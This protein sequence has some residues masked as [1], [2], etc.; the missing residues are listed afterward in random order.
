MNV[1]AHIAALDREGRLMAESAAANGL[2]AVVAACPGWRVRDLLAHTGQVHRWAAAHVA[3]GNGGPPVRGQAAK[4]VFPHPGDDTLLDWFRD[5]H[6]H[7]VRTLSDAAPDTECLTFLPAPSPLAFWARRQ[8][9][10]TAV[11]RVDAQSAHPE[12]APAPEEG[13]ADPGD[14]ALAADGVEELLLGFFARP[15]G[16]LVADPPLVL[17]LETTDTGQGWTMSLTPTGRTST[18]GTGPDA[19]T[20]VTGPAHELYLLLWNRSGGGRCTVTGDRGAL[21]LWRERARVQWRR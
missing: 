17:A 10:E 14:P 16:P 4:A 1:T 5:G 15:G 19:D 6:A 18:R 21:D 9:H 8:A 12:H 3:S 7:L 11:H 2:D 20:T 13:A